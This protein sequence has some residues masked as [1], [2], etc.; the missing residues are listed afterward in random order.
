MK[1]AVDEAALW[2]RK[3]AAHA[4][5]TEAIKMAIRAGVASIEHGS[6]IDDEG[7]RMMKE[8]GT[9]LVDDIYNDDYIIA[10]YT[11]L[12]YPQ[13]ILDKERMVGRLRAARIFARHSRPEE[14]RVRHR[15]G[16]LPARLERETIREVSR[17]G[18]DTDASNPVRDHKRSRFDRLENESRP[19]RA[20]LLRGSSG[21][22]RRSA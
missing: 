5:G 9:W 16:G 6:L 7:I 3:V 17:M 11:R 2:G 19:A 4:H 8:H 20:G 1:A 13:K 12:G 10:E 21:R 14:V 15:R 18:H 22:Q